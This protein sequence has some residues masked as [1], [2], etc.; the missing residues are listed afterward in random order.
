MLP[1]IMYKEY[2]TIKPCEMTI[3]S[4][5]RNGVNLSPQRKTE[6]ARIV[7]VIL[8]WRCEFYRENGVFVHF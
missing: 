1:S 5:Q 2:L 3:Q 6:S 7:L 4:F 8:G